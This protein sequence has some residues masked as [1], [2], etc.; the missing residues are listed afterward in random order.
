MYLFLI[1]L[2]AFAMELP[3][4]EVLL[5]AYR[6][7][8]VLPNLS[9]EE[10]RLTLKQYHLVF[11][12]IYSHTELKTSFFNKPELEPA[13]RV[14]A[15][16]PGN[17]I[18]LLNNLSLITLQLRDPHQSVRWPRPYSC[19]RTFV[20]VE[21]GFASQVPF[22]RQIVVDH[23]TFDTVKNPQL[24][25]QLAPLAAQM[26]LG[27]VVL[28]INGEDVW[29]ALQKSAVQ[30][31][32][33]NEDAYLYEG[34]F[35][36]T[37]SAQR[38]SLLPEVDSLSFELK[39][40]DEILHIEIPY[41]VRTSPTCIEEDKKR[42]LVT[43]QPGFR[44]SRSHPMAADFRKQK[45][46]V[47]GLQNRFNV[48]PSE[49]PTVSFATL[50]LA[51]QQYGYLRITQ[52]SPE[53][54]VKKAQ[55]EIAKIVKKFEKTTAGLIID[56]RGNPGGEYGDYLTQY[57]SPNRVVAQTEE[58]RATDVNLRILEKIKERNNE[59]DEWLYVYIE[60]VRK[61]L[62][63]GKR[64]SERVLVN[65]DE[66]LNE[67]GRLYSHPVIVLAD[68]S[69][70]SYCDYFST[71]MQDNHAAEIWIENGRH[72]GG[73][74]GSVTGY[75]DFSQLLPA[76]FLPLPQQQDIGIAFSTGYRTGDKAGVPIEN[77]GADADVVYHTTFRDV[78]QDDADLLE[79]IAQRFSQWTP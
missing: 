47:T 70:Y 39:R 20:P 8:V 22:D 52:F 28:K 46:S 11:N 16:A 49:E 56:V 64:Y 55:K 48:S 24:K 51:E 74:G 4:D 33:S 79:K 12:E 60:P 31:G 32:G 65:T 27:D 7:Q 30:G 38:Q 29:T 78:Q 53:K 15:L 72:T 9:E 50:T 5:S 43:R 45:V 19:L 26:Q 1:I 59:D 2:S 71:S 10:Q 61:A 25:K 3:K 6:P 68:P 67:K 17:T 21:L 36:L 34:L 75:G 63:E 23:L 69:C 35:F 37:Y 77:L 73:G 40:G 54:G 57:F 76:V 41:L 44:V 58:M 13:P 18:D 66:Y 62:L 14:A 42:P